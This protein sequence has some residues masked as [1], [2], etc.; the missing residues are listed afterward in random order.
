MHKILLIS[1]SFI[2]GLYAIEIPIEKVQIHEFGKSIELN[3]KIVQLS[4]AKQSIMTLLD[5]QITEYY[6]KE[7]ET[8]NKGQKKAMFI[9][10]VSS[11]R[12]FCK[13]GGVSLKSS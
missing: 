11:K 9:H 4:S 12:P 8:V 7:G 6:V 5:G 13:I 3:S 10:K 2:I 1:L